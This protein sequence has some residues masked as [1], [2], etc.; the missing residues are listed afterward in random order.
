MS[1][2]L[3]AVMFTACASSS[4]KIAPPVEAPAPV[5][6]PVS[7]APAAETRRAFPKLDPAIYE[8]RIARAGQTNAPTIDPLP[9]Y[10]MGVAACDDLLVRITACKTLP[11]KPKVFQRVMWNLAKEKLDQG[12]DRGEIESQCTQEAESWNLR[13]PTEHPGC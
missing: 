11:N 5:A 4:S 1:K 7:P 9:E 10:G 8:A 3:A 6:Q 13:L 2:L 12:G